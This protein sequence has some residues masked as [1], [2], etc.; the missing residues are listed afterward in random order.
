MKKWFIYIIAL[1]CLLIAGFCIYEYYNKPEKN[2][3]AN[4]VFTTDANYTEYTK[5]AIKS[6]IVNKAPDTEYNIIMLCVDLSDKQ[7]KEF[8]QFESDKVKINL[9]P[10]KVDSIKKVGDYE[11]SNHVSRADLFKFFMPEIL[12]DYDKVLYMDSDTIILGDLLPLFNTN[13]RGKC[14]GAVPKYVPI[15]RWYH[16]LGEFFIRHE[17]YEYNCGIMLLN[18]EQM[19][20]EKVTEKLVVSKNS[21]IAR[22]LMTQDAF[23]SVLP[24]GKTK[25]LSPIYNTI[26]RWKPVY[27][28]SYNFKKTFRPYL[29]NINSMEELYKQSVI[30]HFAGFR[31]PWHYEDIAF[32]KEWWKYAHMINPNWKLTPDPNRE[33]YEA[34]LIW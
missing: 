23:N 30:I 28:V 9:L 19:R 31:K 33:K 20:K 21:D 12:K 4:L 10:L 15:Y 24:F 27:F 18:L 22:N 5:V 11:V 13:L 6:A 1:F 17:T 32:S 14:L 25:K 2:S 26:A 34:A 8:K 7:M 3:T 29:N 16:V